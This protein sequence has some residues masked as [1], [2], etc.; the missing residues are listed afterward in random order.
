MKEGERQ[1]SPT[2]EGI[3]KD[4]L[5][6]YYWATDHL[7][8][9]VLDAACG[10]GYGSNI[11][12][13]S[14]LEVRAVDIDKEAIRYAKKYYSH[15]DIDFVCSDINQAG[16]FF[17]DTVAFE[18]IEHVEHPIRFLERLRGKLLA[19]V[20]NEDIF[21]YKGYAFH[22]RHYTKGE[23]EALLNEAGFEI[24][25]WW[26]QLGDSSPVE[27]DVNGRTLIAIASK[28]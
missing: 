16:P 26:G 24:E 3:R 18:M 25:S 13:T 15:P 23:F 22:Y 20:P 5:S 17:T 8:G 11:L 9:R 12:A 19:S 6:R 10:V 4:H 28:Q 2:L 27:P 21:P 7:E 1:V 14:G